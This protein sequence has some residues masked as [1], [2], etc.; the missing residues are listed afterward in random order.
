[1]KNAYKLKATLKD[2]VWGGRK[3]FSYGFSSSADKIAEAWAISFHKDG[4]SLTADGI[5]AKKGDGFFYSRGQNC[6]NNGRI[7]IR[8][9]FYKE[10][11]YKTII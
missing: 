6:K 10:I 5:P 3:L 7:E 11:I 1:M 8:R 2:Y 9:N 4:M